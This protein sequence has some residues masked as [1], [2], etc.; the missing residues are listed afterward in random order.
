MTPESSEPTDRADR[1]HLASAWRDLGAVLSIS[2]PV[3]VA[4][5]S[6]TLMGFVDTWLLAEYG[7]DEVAS[8][9][10]AGAVVFIFIAFVFG[11]SNCTSAFVAQ[12]LGRGRPGDCSR[13]AWQGIYFGVLAQAALVP[14]IVF[15]SHIF[16][17]FGHETAVQAMETT[18]FRI[19]LLH[20]AA[21][22]AYAA[23]TSFFQ[24]IGKPVIAMYAAL[25]ANVLNA[26]LDAVLIFGLWGFP[27]MGITGAAVATVIASY[28]QVGLL[29]AAFF[30]G[31]MRR[32]FAT[33]KLWRPDPVRFWQLMR[34]GAPAGLS[35]MLHTASW[36]IFTNVL[37]GRLGS[38]ILA[39]NN[40]T[41][42]IIRLSFMPAIGVSKGVTVLV[43]QSVGRRDIPTAKRRA[44]AGMG[45]AMLY[46]TL[47]GV[48]F[49]VFRGQIIRLFRS[50]AVIVEAGSK[51][52][53]LAAV[54]QAF[55]ALGIVS[56]GALRGAGDTRFP[57]I[58][59]VA[60][61]WLLL[62][63][64]GYALTFPLGMGYVGAWAAAAFMIAVVGSIFFLRFVGEAWRKIDI[65]ATRKGPVSAPTPAAESPRPA[66]R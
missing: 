53:I 63:P 10:A 3:I 65:F 17:A 2:F 32:R 64:L 48:L 30:H 6:H 62:L 58:V 57:A 44:Y 14:A 45:L 33:R 54:F 28:F 18:Y 12:S 16:A 20:A 66:S 43:G 41:H 42:A 55:D 38:S 25:V 39:A 23:L 56:Y 47:M 49:V 50:D 7:R 40:I 24:G 31:P 5:A 29:F 19:R 59:D 4:M 22:A 8:V 36:A 11:T 46:M 13:Y 35:F 60:S 51:M 21:T 26:V 52:L 37:I 61:G 15:G 1:P 34:I 27:E 9:G